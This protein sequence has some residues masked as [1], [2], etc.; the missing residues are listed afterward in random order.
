MASKEATFLLKKKIYA[1]EEA[2]NLMYQ[3]DDELSDLTDND[4][5]DSG[6]KILES[7]TEE[8]GYLDEQDDE[9]QLIPSPSP[10]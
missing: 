8:S 2:V 4:F 5:T 3:T 6:S 10:P 1:A 7:E 9:E